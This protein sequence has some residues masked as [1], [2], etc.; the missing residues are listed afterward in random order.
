MLPTRQWSAFIRSARKA[1]GT[2]VAAG[3]KILLTS[4]R[5]YGRVVAVSWD[6]TPG[7]G[8]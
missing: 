4:P 6:E 3:V 7:I 2:I 1:A 8:L 5:N